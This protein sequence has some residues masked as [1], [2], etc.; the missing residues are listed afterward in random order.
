MSWLRPP[1][2]LPPRSAKKTLA[3]TETGADITRTYKESADFFANKKHFQQQTKAMRLAQRP[4]FLCNI[5]SNVLR[6]KRFQM[7]HFDDVETTLYDVNR[8]W[9]F[10]N[11][12]QAKNSK[13]VAWFYFRLSFSFITLEWPFD[14]ISC[15][16]VS[17]FK[18]KTCCCRRFLPSWQIFD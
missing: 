8:R 1:P 3:E 15:M 18:S 11:R 10:R 4:K 5:G 17:S 13:T 6:R 9:N 7:I 14:V 12:Q 2:P 16:T